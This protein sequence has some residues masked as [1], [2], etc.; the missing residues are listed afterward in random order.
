MKSGD[1]E[2]EGYTV[3]YEENSKDVGSYKVTVTFG[4][5]E[6]SISG[7]AEYI[8]EPAEITDVTV[9]R[10]SFTYNGGVQKPSVVSVKAGGLKLDPSDYEA[11]YSDSSSSAVG[12]YALTVEGKGNFSGSKTVPYSIKKAANP[13]AVSGR[14]ATVKF[15]KLRRRSQTVRA[16]KLMNISGAQGDVTY[17]LVSVKKAK[18][19]KYFRVDEKTGSV[20]VKKNLRRGIY[21]LTVNVNAAGNSNY[22]AD[23][24]DV[25]CRI[26]VK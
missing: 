2:V 1:E 16:P 7:T 12:D 26:T 5:E 21:T 14:T 10:T 13:L 20:T 9:N 3:E 6:Y 4:L 18:C 8:I 22:N 15:K 25:V 24:K 19:A 23:S 11:K 17:S